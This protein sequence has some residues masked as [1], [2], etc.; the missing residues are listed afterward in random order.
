[1]GEA[2]RHPP[3]VHTTAA[4]VHETSDVSIRP[5]AI[6]LAWLTALIILVLIV[7]AW[8]FSVLEHSAERREPEPSPLAEEHPQTRG[9]LLQVSAREDL[10]TLRAREDQVLASAA[11][12]DKDRQLARIPIDRAMQFVAQQGLPKWPPPPEDKAQP[13]SNDRAPLKPAASS[14]QGT[15]QT[16][17]IQEGAHP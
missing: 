14:P 13:G 1:M 16:T 10:K 8:L 11:W 5:L 12:I 9:P 2:P 7:C 15:G 3:Q 6:F 17:P 4:A